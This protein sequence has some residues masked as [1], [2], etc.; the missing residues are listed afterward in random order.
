MEDVIATGNADL[1]YHAEHTHIDRETMIDIMF[2]NTSTMG[3]YK[4][5]TLID[6]VENRR[7]EIEAIFGEPLR[8]AQS[9]K[10]P[11]PHLALLT[12]LLRT[13]NSDRK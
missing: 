2:K 5:S 6:F 7:M 12:A 10:I 8:R 13:L 3:A 1:A 4:P 11:V 9:L